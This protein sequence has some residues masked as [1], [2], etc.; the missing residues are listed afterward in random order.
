M[1][2]KEDKI[3]KVMKQNEII[4]KS[5]CLENKHYRFTNGDRV[6]WWYRDNLSEV[7]SVLRRDKESKFEYHPYKYYW[8]YSFR[9]SLSKNVKIKQGI[10]IFKK[11]I[12]SWPVRGIILALIL[13]TIKIIF[14]IEL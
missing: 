2:N 14:K 3:N 12:N 1:K 11:T 10:N 8:I 9:Y 7:N 13:Y 5:L 6:V 4:S